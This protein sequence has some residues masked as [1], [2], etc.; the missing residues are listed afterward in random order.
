MVK[1][2]ERQYRKLSTQQVPCAFEIENFDTLVNFVGQEAIVQSQHWQA[3]MAPVLEIDEALYPVMVRHLSTLSDLDEWQSRALKDVA[4]QLK[5]G[6]GNDRYIRALPL[7]GIHSKFIESFTPLL[8]D[9]LDHL[10][11][12]AVSE[13]GGL[14]AW[15]GCLD[16]PKGWLH[17]RP[18]CEETKKEMGGFS[19][20][21]ISTTELKHQ[22]L[23]ARNILIVE[24][25]ESGLSLPSL[26][27]TIAVFG[28]GRNVSWT[29]AAWLKNKNVAYWGDIDTWGLAILSDVRKNLPNVQAV[30]MD[31]ETLSLFERFSTH[32]PK[33]VEMMPLYLTEEEQALFSL[34]KSDPKNVTRLEQELC[35]SDYSHAVLKAWQGSA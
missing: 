26:P 19:A 20:L 1:W 9:I 28:G 11:D 33:S 25:V 17:I 23:P 4:L 22:P 10:Y 32:E 2:E 30:M 29:D 24:N 6:M 8:T 3:M 5:A 13:S 18:L 35:A 7:T 12:N 27:D 14:T 15:L 21:K 31:E 34:L 16:R